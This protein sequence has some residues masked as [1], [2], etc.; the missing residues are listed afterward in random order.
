MSLRKYIYIFRGK[1]MTSKDKVEI[2]NDQFHFIAVGVNHPREAI[3]IAEKAVNDGVE[4][5]ELCGGLGKNT[6]NQIVSAINNAVPVGYTS[7]PQTQ[8]TIK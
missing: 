1:G 7:Y 3:A 4:A 8:A 2:K 5:I 6:A